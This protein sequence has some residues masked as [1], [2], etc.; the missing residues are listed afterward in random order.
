MHNYCV[1]FH[2]FN[3]RA[4]LKTDV[5]RIAHNRHELYRTCAYTYRFLC[6]IQTKDQNPVSQGLSIVLSGGIVLY[7][8]QH[9]ISLSNEEQ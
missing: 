9:H 2:F 8:I 7:K 3:E 6:L 1:Y 5:E 4:M